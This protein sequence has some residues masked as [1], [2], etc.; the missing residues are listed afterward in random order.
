M[1]RLRRRGRFFA[2][3]A[4]QQLDDCLTHL[5]KLGAELLQHLGG[6]TLTLTDEAEQDVL[7]ADVV[8]A[9]LKRFA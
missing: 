6:D 4:G 2:L 8:V 5:V 7:G 1:R 3:D 9:E